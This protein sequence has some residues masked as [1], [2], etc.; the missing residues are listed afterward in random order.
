MLWPTSRG[1]VRHWS[2]MMIT[3][4]VGGPIDLNSAAAAAA[5]HHRTPDSDAIRRR[6]VLHQCSAAAGNPG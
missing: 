6:L 5:V 4:D 1:G 2:L 3:R